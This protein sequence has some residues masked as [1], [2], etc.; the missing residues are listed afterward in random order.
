MTSPLH[1]L[2]NWDALMWTCLLVSSDALNEFGSKILADT[3]TVNHP[4]LS[5]FPSY[6]GKSAEITFHGLKLTNE[7][8]SQTVLMTRNTVSQNSPESSQFA[9]APKPCF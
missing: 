1:A 5:A 3:E 9:A 8:P 2:P 6:L 4:E 7:S